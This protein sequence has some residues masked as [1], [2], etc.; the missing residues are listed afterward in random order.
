MHPFREVKVWEKSHQVGLHVYR[1]TAGFPVSEQF[2]LTG[3]LR[4]AAVAVPSKIAEG[5]GRGNDKDL[6][7]ALETARG[8]AMDLEYQ[9]ILAR[10]L[11]YLDAE[12]HV[13]LSAEIFEIH[14]MLAGFI[15]AVRL[16]LEEAKTAAKAA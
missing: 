12:E 8:Y 11:E 6:A 7:R 5:C 4:R 1:A 3:Q 10:D 13:A 9:L 14:K 16:R 15:K 2:G